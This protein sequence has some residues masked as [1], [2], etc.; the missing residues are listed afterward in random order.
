VGEFPSELAL[1]RDGQY[2]YVANQA[3][4]GAVVISTAEDRVVGAVRVGSRYIDD[5]E[6]T[7]DGRFLLLTD[8]YGVKYVVLGANVVVDSAGGCARSRLVQCQSTDTLYVVA[9]REVLVMC[10]G[11]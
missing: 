7:P 3:D 11:R 10:R 6:P 4:S 9:G 1:S 8:W 2:L 5:I